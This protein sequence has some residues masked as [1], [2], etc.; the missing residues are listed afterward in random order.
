MDAEKVFLIILF[1]GIV[2]VIIFADAKVFTNSHSAYFTT[3]EATCWN[4]LSLHICCRAAT[5]V[6]GTVGVLPQISRQYTRIAKERVNLTS[7]KL[8][9]EMP[10]FMMNK[11]LLSLSFVR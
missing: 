6:W 10:T 5:R 8:S 4:G 11:E 7:T 1:Q 3:E 9:M 2:T